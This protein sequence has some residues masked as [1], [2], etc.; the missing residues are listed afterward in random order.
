MVGRPDTKPA[1]TRP[2]PS[3]GD[4]GAPRDTGGDAAA[5]LARLRRAFEQ[6]LWAPER[7][8]ARKAA[9]VRAL[10]RGAG[11]LHELWR[12][13][14]RLAATLRADLPAIV[15]ASSGNAT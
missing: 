5:R 6:E 10:N 1:S 15:R 14:V 9:V 3:G 2:A 4:P 7:A 11:W 12:Q 8:S 13:T